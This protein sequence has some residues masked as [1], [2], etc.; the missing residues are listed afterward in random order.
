[1]QPGSPS[2][3]GGCWARPFWRRGAS[4]AGRWGASRWI[5]W[6]DTGVE[7][8]LAARLWQVLG[9]ISHGIAGKSTWSGLYFPLPLLRVRSQPDRKL[10]SKGNI[11][12]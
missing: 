8:G 4:R 7:D 6:L 1:M 9:P 11:T 2:S 3:N 5:G 12:P 10:A